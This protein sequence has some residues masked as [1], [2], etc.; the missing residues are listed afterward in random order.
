MINTAE[1]ESRYAGVGMIYESPDIGT[2]APDVGEFGDYTNWR[3]IF[4][5]VILLNLLC[6]PEI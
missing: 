5:F 4:R 2:D 3:Y 6:A 1:E